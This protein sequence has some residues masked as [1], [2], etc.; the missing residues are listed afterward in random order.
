MFVE[1]DQKVK[2][3]IFMTAFATLTSIFFIMLSYLYQ[4]Y[5][6]QILSLLI[7]ILPMIYIIGGLI[8]RG[9][10]DNE[11]SKGLEKTSEG[12]EDMQQEINMLKKE[13]EE[14]RAKI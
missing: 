8:I 9:I 10:L 1:L 11:Y 4:E 12:I 6:I 13:N 7:I 2:L 3:D 5:A 14:L